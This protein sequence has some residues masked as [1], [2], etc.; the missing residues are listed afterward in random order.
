[1]L[2]L[3]HANLVDAGAPPAL[4]VN[5]VQRWML[6]PG[7]TPVDG[8][9]PGHVTAVGDLDLTDPALWGALYHRGR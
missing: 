7:R 5:A 4:A 2:M 1:M 3:L 6:G 9:P 8:V